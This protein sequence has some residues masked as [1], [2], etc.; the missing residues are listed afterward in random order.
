MGLFSFISNVG[1][2]IFGQGEDEAKAIET[3]LK[4][5]LGDKINDLKAEFAGG[6]VTLYGKCDS[7][8]TKEKA[9]LLAGNLKDVERVN[10]ENLESPASEEVTEFYTVKSGDSLWK[11][12]QEFYGNGNKYQEIFE[13]NKEVI[14]NPD[15]IY[16]GQTLRIPKKKE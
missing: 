14:K 4:K 13:A 5:D 9:V 10:D 16:P 12:A 7:F 2:S 3:L 6:L 8:A 1:K 15:L 11:I